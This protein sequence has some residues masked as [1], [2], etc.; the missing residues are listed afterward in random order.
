MQCYLGP[1][2][3][4]NTS[5][6]ARSTFKQKIQV[7]GGLKKAGIIKRSR[8][9][10]MRWPGNTPIPTHPPNY[11]PTYIS[12]YLYISTNLST[13]PPTYVSTYP[14]TRRVLPITHLLIPVGC[15]RTSLETKNVSMKGRPCSTSILAKPPIRT[16]LPSPSR[17]VTCST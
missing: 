1:C 15:S 3:R 17:R 9:K 2:V 4:L 10:K 11:L 12:T 16:E 13:Y 5:A 7:K 6:A 14:P 8:E